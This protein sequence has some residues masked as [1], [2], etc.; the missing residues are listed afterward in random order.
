MTD[1][2]VIERELAAYVPGESLGGRPIADRTRVVVLNKADV[3]DARELAELV[4]PELEARGLEVHIVS[5][6]AHTGLKALTYAL[7]RRV[8]EARAR[9]EAE[10]VERP[11]VVLRP[12]GRRRHGVPRRQGGHRRRRRVPR[13]RRPADQVGP[14]DG[15][16]QRRGGGLPR[17]PARPA[18]R[19]GRALRRR[20]GSRLDRPH[21]P[22]AGRRRVRLGADDVCRCL[23][24]P[25]ERGG[26]GR[27]AR[28]RP[29]VRG[30]SAAG[31]APRGVEEFHARKDA[32]TAARDELAEEREAG[33]WTRGRRCLTSG[34]GSGARVR[35]ARRIVVKVGS[36]SLTSPDGGHLD[37]AR[38]VGLVD[39]IAARRAAGG[40]GRPRVLRRDRRRDG[41][42]VGLR[43]RPGD[44]ATQQ[45]AASVGQ[46]ALVAAYQQ[47]FGVHGLTVGQVLLT[48]DDVTRR[49]PL[50]E[51]PA[52]P[53]AAARA[54]HRARSSTRTTPSRPT[55]SGSAT[56]TV[57]PPSS[58]TSSRRTRSSC[59][60]TSTRS[61]TG[62]RAGPGSVRVP[63][64]AGPGRPR[65]GDDRGEPARPSAA[66]GC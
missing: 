28:D 42:A 65:R 34:P 12:A 16:H 30:P 47:A 44:L 13:A 58:P 63:V 53:R 33:H 61:T 11:R 23:G 46:G 57:S 51:R 55:R 3:P 17:R 48:A 62:R 41:S 52:H 21:R 45:A 9:V 49:D 59:S 29:P 32:Q 8:S 6:V 25:A 19:R 56:T 24:E 35:D 1:L 36:S 37:Q 38:L 66:A 10:V 39:L 14:A 5:A 20:R 18:R 7:A 26:A 64:V 27:A 43:R 40:A 60:P 2:D 54:R 22:G 50:H 15:L 31:A 4:K